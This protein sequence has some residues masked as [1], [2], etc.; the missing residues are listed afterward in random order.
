ML[1]IYTHTMRFNSL[2]VD[3]NPLIGHLWSEWETSP[4][5]EILSV[6]HRKRMGQDTFRW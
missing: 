2:L 4:L 3:R 6:N 5:T 1:Y